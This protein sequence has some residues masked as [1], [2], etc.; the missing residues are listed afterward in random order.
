VVRTVP[1]M[2]FPP[3]PLGRNT[4]CAVRSKP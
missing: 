4:R 1:A 2:P 3:V